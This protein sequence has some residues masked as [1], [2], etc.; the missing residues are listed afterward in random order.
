MTG[1]APSG[2]DLRRTSRDRDQLR[3]A[4]QGWLAGKLPA[5]ADPRILELTSSAATGMSSETVLFPA[6]WNDPRD[7]GKVRTEDL[8]CRIAPHPDDVP[9]FPSYDMRGQFEV[10][11]KVGELTSVP[12]PN[13]RWLEED[14]SLIGTPFFLMDRIEGAAPPD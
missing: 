1:P 13:V 11:R 4:L 14:T 10:I 3:V 8:V 6:I 5:G 2:A 7:G 12:V 9:V